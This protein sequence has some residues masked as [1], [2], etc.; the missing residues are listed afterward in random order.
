MKPYIFITRKIPEA[1]LNE[2][3]RMAD[4]TMWEEE[5]KPVPRD[6]LLKEAAKATG[7]LTMLS[8]KIDAELMDQS[9]NLKVVANL[10][11]GYDNIDIPYADKKGMIICNTPDVL[12]DTTADL[13]FALLMATARR[14]TE[15]AQY[16]KEGKWT[17][18]SP[19]LLA[20]TDIHHKTLGIVGMGRIGEAVA[21]R[22]A[23]FDMNILYHNRSRKEEAERKLGL[24]YRSFEDLLKASDYVV[25]LAPL[26]EETKDLFDEK[27][28]QMM[29]SSA[30]F[31]NASRGGVVVENALDKALTKGW[32]KGA[33]LDVFREEPI[34]PEHFLL[35]H[36]NLVAL[37]HIGS[38]SLETRMQMA[39]LACKN[40]E[41]VLQGLTPP[42][43]VNVQDA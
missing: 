22:A 18:W 29:K 43:P 40:I 12:T 9:P 6:R 1:S 35:K 3:Q 23:G 4:V 27:A 36:D 42:A 14:I 11:V 16:L 20:G 24:S 39:R 28:F 33:G 38:A 37:P 19:L 13:T 32:I 30:L 10:A 8:D 5:L 26:T 7:L 15:A 41:N 31:I 25:C 17:G 21:K 2:L 34:H